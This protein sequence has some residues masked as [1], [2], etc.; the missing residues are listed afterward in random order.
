MARPR[1]RVMLE[2]Y[3][4]LDLRKLGLRAN[5]RLTARYRYS[6]GLNMTVT[7]TLGERWGSMVLE[8][9]G[10]RQTIELEAVSRH[11]GGYQ[12]FTR[13]PVSHRRALVLW[14]PA[15]SPIFASR[16]A[17]PG[18]V[19]HATQFEDAVGRAWAAKRRVVRR[20]GSTDP[21]DYDLRRRPKGMRRH[22]YAKLTGRYWAAEQALDDHLFQFMNR[23]VRRYGPID[24]GLKTRT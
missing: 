23:L 17:W 19:A 10:R 15:G 5:R 12:W 6:S 11:L 4:K 14:R 7:A 24:L 18:Q 16:R 9:D 8:Y 2:A 20:L 3:P 13:C 22:T 21:N 1:R